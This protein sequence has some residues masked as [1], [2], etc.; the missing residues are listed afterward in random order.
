MAG[1]SADKMPDEK[2]SDGYTIED[3]EYLVDEGEV[4]V[5]MGAHSALILGMK[6]A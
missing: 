4:V 6:E 3:E 5:N 1:G 2:A